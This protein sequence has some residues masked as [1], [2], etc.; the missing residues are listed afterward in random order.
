MKTKHRRPNYNFNKTFKNIHWQIENY[1]TGGELRTLNHCN[2]NPFMFRHET[3]DDIYFYIICTKNPEKNAPIDPFERF[4]K[5]FSRS[6][7]FQ[8]VKNKFNII[9][10]GIKSMS[11]DEFN[12]SFNICKLLKDKINSITDNIFFDVESKDIDND[13]K[14][15]IQF[16]LGDYIVSLNLLVKHFAIKKLICKKKDNATTTDKRIFENINPKN[17]L[18]LLN[19]LLFMY[20][21]KINTDDDNHKYTILLEN[22][23]NAIANTEIIFKHLEEDL[24]YSNPNQ[25]KLVFFKIEYLISEEFEMIYD[26]IVEMKN[27]AFLSKLENYLTKNK[28]NLKDLFFTFYK[29]NIFTN[30]GNITIEKN[31]YNLFVKLFDLL[32]QNNNIDDKKLLLTKDIQDI[33]YGHL[34]KNAKKDF[35]QPLKIL[36]NNMPIFHEN[37]TKFLNDALNWANNV[38]NNNVFYFDKSKNVNNTFEIVFGNYN[39]YIDKNN[40][41]KYIHFAKFIIE[42]MGNIN[43]VFDGIVYTY[44]FDAKMVE[45]ILMNDD[46]QTN[47]NDKFTSNPLIKNIIVKNYEL[48]KDPNNILYYRTNHLKEYWNIFANKMVYYAMRND[49]NNIKKFIDLTQSPISSSLITPLDEEDLT[50][51]DE[52]SQL[53]RNLQ[54]IDLLNEFEKYSIELN[55]NGTIENKWKHINGIYK[56]L[57]EFIKEMIKNN[58]EIDI[59]IIEENDGEINPIY[60]KLLLCY[61]LFEIFIFMYKNNNNEIKG[62]LIKYGFVNI[63]LIK[64][65]SMNKN[66]ITYSEI[67]HVWNFYL[68]ETYFNKIKDIVENIQKINSIPPNDVKVE[69]YEEINNYDFKIK[70]VYV[71]D[72]IKSIKTIYINQI[73]TPFTFFYLYIKID[74]KSNDFYK[75]IKDQFNEINAYNNN[76]NF[77]D[78][79]YTNS[80]DKKIIFNKYENIIYH[81]LNKSILSKN[82]KYSKGIYEKIIKYIY[83]NFKSQKKV[84]GT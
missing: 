65:T 35:L 67:E 7:N 29:E 69:F 44:K 64:D 3:E 55:E 9:F 76:G 49:E 33:F 27:S 78:G 25:T 63:T 36:G 23:S 80:D 4:Y 45:H 70:N 84:F 2:D 28:G 71:E 30:S 75:K 61:T 54:R 82:V 53:I 47:F 16:K 46:F 59:P 43:E 19:I 22:D 68:T 77:N 18:Q 62:E 8:E 10:N 52:N 31:D 81:L 1:K 60:F 37:L 57:V 58:V 13:D 79:Y 26:K 14:S 5:E 72:E 32:N 40:A 73:R 48:L 17:I 11:V 83:E 12:D 42:E 38:T 51:Y 15:T 41:K 56:N 24:D 74:F 39:N 20:G 66:S 21:I 34:I 6:P 50:H